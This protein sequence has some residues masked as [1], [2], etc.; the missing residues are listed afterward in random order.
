MDEIIG[1]CAMGAFLIICALPWV[2]MLLGAVWLLGALQSKEAERAFRPVIL[3]LAGVVFPFLVFIA[4]SL[5][6]PEWKGA[7]RFGWLDCFHTGK[8][9][10]TPLVLW[11]CAAFVKYHKGKSEQPI[12]AWVV[13]GLFMGTVVSS[14]CTVVEFLVSG[15]RGGWMGG[16]PCYVSVWYAKLALEAR[17]STGLPLRYYLRALLASI[18]LWVWGIIWSKATYQGL[19][20]TAPEGCFIVTAASR[21]HESLVGPFSNIERRG[22]MRVV[23]RQL[24]VFWQ[25]E[26]LWQKQSPKTHQRFRRIYNRVGPLVAQRVRSKFVADA[27]YLLLKPFE[28]IVAAMVVRGEK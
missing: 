12:P 4:S 24:L 7:C 6:V 9:A 3:C 16:V 10:L 1:F 11:A 23:N 28:V 14:V 8:L 18:P 17:W 5:L 21:G 25:F 20:N 2:S 13:L 26:A 19:S 27:V 22:T 15:F